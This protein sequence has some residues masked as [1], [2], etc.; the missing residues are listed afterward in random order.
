MCVLCS[1]NAQFVLR[2]DKRCRF[3][4]ASMQGDVGQAL[5]RKHGIDPNNPS[6]MIVVQ[7]ESVLADSDAVLS[8]YADLGWPWRALAWA[9]VVPRLVRDPFYRFVARHRYRIFGRRDVCWMP[10]PDQMDRVL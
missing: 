1:A 7:G 10:T 5:Y 2:Y 9:R 6:T 4:L 8:I 3:R